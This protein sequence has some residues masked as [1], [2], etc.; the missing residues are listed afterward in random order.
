M[1]DLPL[2]ARNAGTAH[3]SVRA[4]QAERPRLRHRAAFSPAAHALPQR[5]AQS[6]SLC[7]RTARDSH[8]ERLR[9]ESGAACCCSSSTAEPQS[10]HQG[11]QSQEA[12][13]PPT[14]LKAPG[15]I[16]AGAKVF[17]MALPQCCGQGLNVVDI[18]TWLTGT[19]HCCAAL[20][21]VLVGDGASSCILKEAGSADSPCDVVPAPMKT[22]GH[23][24]KSAGLTRCCWCVGAQL[25]TST[26]T[27]RRRSQR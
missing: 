23:A 26:V 10:I 20:H 8:Q 15:R 14:F 19:S 6:H 12:Y 11:Q 4:C 16:I 7:V 21:T 22:S 13:T 2:G 24:G 3:K 27:C 5:R 17:C 1:A 9:R 25:G 18:L